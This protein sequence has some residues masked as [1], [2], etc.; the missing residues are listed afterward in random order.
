[1]LK[2]FVVHIVKACTRYPKMVLL[3]AVALTGLSAWYTSEHFALN[4]DIS[5][6]ISPNLDWRKREVAFEKAFPGSHET[7]VAVVEAPTAELTQLATRALQNRLESHTKE[8][9]SVE[10]TAG[11]P[12]FQQFV[13]IFIYS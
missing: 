2:S 1:M 6:L 12:F 3:I 4:T 11:S 7:I 8:F 10:N 13:H 5:K 9:K